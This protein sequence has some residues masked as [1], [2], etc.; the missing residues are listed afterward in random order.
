MKKLVF[1]LCLGAMA[2]GQSSC[3]LSGTPVEPTPTELNY[4]VN[5]RY[6]HVRFMDMVDMVMYFV[7]LQ[8]NNP[9]GTSVPVGVTLTPTP[10]SGTMQSM[11]IEFEGYGSRTGKLNITFQ[12]GNPLAPGSKMIVRPVDLFY[13]ADKLEGNMTIE[14]VGDASSKEHIK[15]TLPDGKITYGTGGD[16]PFICAFERTL[17]LKTGS[18]TTNDV[19]YQYTLTGYSSSLTFDTKVSYR[20]SIDPQSPIVYTNYPLVV[21]AGQY[22]A[23][24]VYPSSGQQIFTILTYTEPFYIKYSAGVNLLTFTFQGVSKDYYY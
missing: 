9:S 23:G 10:E 15:I 11:V 4:F 21:A 16:L 2:V 19:D 6:S 12:D 8:A 22:P 1:A 17:K 13:G 7:N 14:I 20:A 18:T 3:N 5:N 24:R